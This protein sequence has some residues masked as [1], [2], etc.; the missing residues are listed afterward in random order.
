MAAEKSSSTNHII[1]SYIL[2]HCEEVRDMNITD[3]AKACYVGT[4]SVSRFVRE[5]GLESYSQLRQLI[6]ESEFSFENVR[7]DAEYAE[8]RDLL[9]EYIANSIRTAAASVDYQQLTKLCRDIHDHESVFACGHLKAQSA[10]VSLQTDLLMM[11]KNIRTSTAF[12]EQI[13]TIMNAGKED[14][15]IIFSYTGSYFSSVSLRAREQHLLLPKI[16]MVCG[17]GSS[18]DWFVD[19]TL[20]FASDAKRG[21]HPF[22]LET[23]ASLITNEYAVLYR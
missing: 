2:S 14:L 23:A 3:L 1:A 7:R 15:I 5:I 16:W 12:N 18:A 13:D 17:E 6:A 21:A 9:S 4:G 19:E 8:R 10:A 20:T 22:L 11:G